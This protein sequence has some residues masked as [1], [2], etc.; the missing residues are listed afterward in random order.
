MIGE[1]IILA[2]RS[3]ESRAGQMFIASS[4]HSPTRVLS[5]DVLGPRTL[6]GFEYG[7]PLHQFAAAIATA[8][9]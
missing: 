5:E 1:G 2:G 4:V 8:P 7:I 3:K 9:K 6:A